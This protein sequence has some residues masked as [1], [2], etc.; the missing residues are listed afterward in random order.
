MKYKL[1]IFL[2]I[3][4]FILSD[5]KFEN[6][7]QINTIGPNTIEP[8]TIEPNTIEPNTIEPNTIEP[9]I[10]KLN[11]IEPNIIKQNIIEP[12][13]IKQ[14][15]IEPNTLA[16]N[17]NEIIFQYTR[18]EECTQTDIWNAETGICKK[19]GQMMD[20]TIDY[21]KPDDCDLNDEWND[22]TGVCTKYGVVINTT[23]KN[24]TKD[25]SLI[26][27]NGDCQ[28][29]NEHTNG[30]DLGKFNTI[31]KCAEECIKYDKC[32]YFTYGN[33]GTNRGRCMM[34]Y[35]TDNECNF[36]NKNERNTKRKLKGY[37]NSINFDLYR[38]NTNKFLRKHGINSK[39]LK[40]QYLNLNESDHINEI[41]ELFD[42][43]NSVKVNKKPWKQPYL[44]SKRDAVI[45]SLK[46]MIDLCEE[47]NGDAIYMPNPNLPEG[48]L[49]NEYYR[50]LKFK[51]DGDIISWN[52]LRLL[53]SYSTNYNVPKKSGLCFT[54]EEELF[55]D[56]KMKKEKSQYDSL[57]NLDSIGLY[58][59]CDSLDFFD[60]KIQLLY[61]NKKRIIEKKNKL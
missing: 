11:K 21:I 26:S 9:N 46:K 38:L 6:F 1:I 45:I 27:I 37:V 40:N 41:I 24:K 52:R 47:L 18:P 33:T 4:L 59:R 30:F 61:L 44:N 60:E 25:Y 19:K 35:S 17:K 14:N 50:I 43:D 7:S 3:T 28:S 13:I 22:I 36:D 57:D 53:P 12:N 56:D 54:D 5:N 15:T 32:K 20:G 2:L 23:K 42:F 39:A 51:Y 48:L 8:N 49:N 31:K 55:K 16:P 10:I 58:I 34:E 29:D